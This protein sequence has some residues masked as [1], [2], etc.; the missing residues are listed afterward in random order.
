VEP[1]EG[2]RSSYTVLVE[3]VEGKASLGKPGID[4]RKGIFFGLVFRK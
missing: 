1:V 2:M 4:I 3:I